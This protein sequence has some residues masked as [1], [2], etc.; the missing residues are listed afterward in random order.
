[1]IPDLDQGLDAPV[2]LSLSEIEQRAEPL[3]E[4]LLG[5]K[6]RATGVFIP[7]DPTTAVVYRLLRKRGIEPSSQMDIVSCGNQASCLAGLTPRPATI[8][9]GSELSGRQ[10]VEQ[11]LWKITNPNQESRM[12]LGVDPLLIEGEIHAPKF[13]SLDTGSPTHDQRHGIGGR[14][15]VIHAMCQN[16]EFINPIPDHPKNTS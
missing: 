6:D 10:A 3:V 16:S 2:L 8:D 4:E 7:Y 11:L 15:A 5:R 14:R 13:G 12:R 1:M 9:V